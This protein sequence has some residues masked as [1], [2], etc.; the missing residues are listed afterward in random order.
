MQPGAARFDLKVPAPLKFEGVTELE[1]R[2]SYA[3]STGTWT[4]EFLSVAWLKYGYKAV[5]GLG[6]WLQD[7][8]RHG[9]P[10]LKLD[11]QRGF[12]IDEWG[13]AVEPMKWAKASEAYA[14]VERR[15]HLADAAA[16]QPGDRPGIEHPFMGWL[17]RD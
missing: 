9:V 1:L 13:L 16:P 11:D 6:Q 10:V 3:K 15:W 17:R 5:A 8:Q 2:L 7:A 14:H 12:P 4:V